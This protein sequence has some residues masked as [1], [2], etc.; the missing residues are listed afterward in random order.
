MRD[1]LI[2]ATACAGCLSTLLIFF[3]AGGLI[4]LNNAVKWTSNEAQTAA[5]FFVQSIT[6]AE[7]QDN[8]HG[9]TPSPSVQP[10]KVRVLVVPGH[11]PDDGGTAMDYIY[12]RDVVVDIADALAFRLSQNP[13]Y[14]AMVARTKTEWNPILQSYFDDSSLEIDAFRQSQTQEMANHIADGKISSLMDKVYHNAAS[15]RALIQLYGI[16]KWTSDNNYDVT[17]HLHLN[18]YAG[19]RGTSSMY[20]GFSIYIPDYQYSNADASRAVGEAIAVRLNAFHATSTLPQESR[21]VIED[22]ELIAIGSNNS[23]DGAAVLIEYGYIAEPQFSEPSIRSVAIADYAYQTYLGLQDF[24]NDTPASTYGSVSFPYN[25]SEVTAQNNDHGA[26]IY[27]LQSA[28]HY[29]GYYPPSGKNFSQCPVSG[30]VGPCTRSAIKAYQT[31]RGL[32]A[33]GTLGPMTRAEL[34]NDLKTL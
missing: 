9:A 16:N 2:L 11:Q 14:D 34:I 33:V 7:I 5:I 10:K 3:I 27:A 31:A 6:V 8:Y 25:W 32:P 13:H 12:E 19:R 29:L 30:Y 15:T 26:G 17:L 24:F 18:D 23:A 4:P 22:Q 20:E 28:L 21:G 1:N